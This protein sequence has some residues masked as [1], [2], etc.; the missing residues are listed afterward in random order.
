MR[1]SEDTL[2]REATH[3]TLI[4]VEVYRKEREQCIRAPRHIKRQAFTTP[5]RIVEQMTRGIVQPVV[6]RAIEDAC[7]T[8]SISAHCIR[9]R[10]EQRLVLL[11]EGDNTREHCRQP[12]QC[13]AI[14]RDETGNIGTKLHHA[15]FEQCG[16]QRG[17]VWVA[18]IECPRPYPRR[19]GN[20]VHAHRV[21]ALCGEEATRRRKHA[22]PV[23]SGVTSLDT[24]L[25]TC[26]LP[27]L[28]GILCFHRD[29]F[30]I[31]TLTTGEFSD[32]LAA[33]TE[34]IP[35]RHPS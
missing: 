22:F 35:F 14:C 24:H 2:R 33:N 30:L 7:G 18:A 1:G 34:R 20:L 21:C 9:H 25:S 4:A 26:A 29:T 28:I 10:A 16:T 5:H 3:L 23:Y 19:T 11:I 6:D 12:W 15:V 32:T 8:G 31:P 27:T 17:F 13:E